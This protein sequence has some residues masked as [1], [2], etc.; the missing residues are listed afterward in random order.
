MAILSLLLIQVEQLSFMHQS[1]VTPAPTYGD[2]W[3]IARLM[4]G[5][6]TFWIPPQCWACDIT[7]IY[8]HEIYYYKEQGYDLQQDL[9]VQ[10]F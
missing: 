3:G 7:Q 9:A 10:G 4:C 5:A 6:L 8:P 2:W 1:V